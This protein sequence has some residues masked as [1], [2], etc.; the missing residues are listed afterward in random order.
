MRK[1]VVLI[2]LAILTVEVIAL[3]FIWHVLTEIVYVFA[4]S[5]IYIYAFI[6]LFFLLLLFSLL[7][8]LILFLNLFRNPPADNAT[9][10][11]W[12]KNLPK[13]AKASIILSAVLIIALYSINLSMFRLNN[14]VPPE[15]NIGIST[16]SSKAID[17]GAINCIK[18]GKATML[19]KQYFSLRQLYPDSDS[20]CTFDFL[21]LYHAPKPLLDAYYMDRLDIHR[22]NPD[23][24]CIKDYRGIEE[25]NYIFEDKFFVCAIRDDDAVGYV[26]IN[27]SLEPDF[28]INENA[29]D[30]MI[31]IFQ[32]GR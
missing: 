7:K 24:V 25:I 11:S 5:F 18:H 27:A 30:L 26:L 1:K 6:P 31:D 14:T 21:L 8:T 12:K 10:S 29:I 23:L 28:S 9:V 16:F 19:S 32:E 17:D 2:R 15:Q 13:A 20:I 22:T 3:A 4:V